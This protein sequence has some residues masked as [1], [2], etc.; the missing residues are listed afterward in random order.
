MFAFRNR[1]HIHDR[2]REALPA[3]KKSFQRYA[4]PGA[5]Y[6]RPS[7]FDLRLIVLRHGE[8]MDKTYGD[9][10]YNDI[11]GDN[12]SPAP[13]MYQ[14]R[15]LPQGL[16]Q[17]SPAFHYLLDPPLTREGQQKA[18]RHGQKLAGQIR[19]VDYCYTS[20]ASR[21]V[22]TA[23]AILKGMNRSRL[24]IR[25][26][27]YLFEPM[28]WNSALQ[29]FSHISPFLSTLDWTKAGFNVNRRYRRI[30][31]QIYRF[32]NETDYFQRTVQVF[33]VLKRHAGAV[34]PPYGYGRPKTILIIG[35][36]ASPTIFPTVVSGQP[37]NFNQF[38]NDVKNVPFLHTIVLER[39]AGTSDWSFSPIMY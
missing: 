28:N 3:K 11:F 7:T 14:N 10:W 8:R 34:A 38:S 21:C 5:N 15:R 25:I 1:R 31:D 37:F 20:P 9:N 35:H 16:P 19:Q 27:P 13:Q 30:N 23:D 39:A 12:P 2:E 6:G 32:E 4:P 26:E 22:L 29:G 24:P 33:D 36:A 17:R 18:Y